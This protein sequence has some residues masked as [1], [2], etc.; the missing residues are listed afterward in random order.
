M[1]RGTTIQEAGYRAGVSWPIVPDIRSAQDGKKYTRYT[2]IAI[3]PAMALSFLI[4]SASGQSLLIAMIGPVAVAALG[5]VVVV[6]LKKVTRELIVNC[7]MVKV[8]A[9]LAGTEVKH[10]AEVVFD[11]VTRKDGE[12]RIA[13]LNEKFGVYVNDGYKLDDGRAF[14]PFIVFIRKAEPVSVEQS[15]EDVAA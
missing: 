7:K 3:L 14:A 12:E 9:D 1:Y 8:I 5:A 15:E 4:L 11:A 10:T 2:M 13:T 6:R